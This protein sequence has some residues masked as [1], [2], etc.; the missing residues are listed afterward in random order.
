MLL[1]RLVKLSEHVI[2][3]QVGGLP[4]SGCIAI[5]W[6][7]TGAIMQTIEKPDKAKGNTHKNLKVYPLS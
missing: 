1:I 2:V 7:P 6:S 5:A 4:L 3:M